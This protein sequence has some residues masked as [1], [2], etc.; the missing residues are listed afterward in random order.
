MKKIDKE[1]IDLAIRA[2]ENS[3]ELIRFYLSGPDA[4]D[5]RQLESSEDMAADGSKA[6]SI[7]LDAIDKLRSL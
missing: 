3:A 2:L 1:S 5:I 6:V 4:Y 7:N